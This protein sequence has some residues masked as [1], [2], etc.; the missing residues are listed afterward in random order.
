MGETHITD[1]ILVNPMLRVAEFILNEAPAELHTKYKTTAYRYI[2]YAKKHVIEKWDARETW[3]TD[4]KYAGYFAWDHYL[5]RDKSAWIQADDVRNSA[6]GLPFNKNLDLAITHLRLFRLVGDPAYR[7]RARLICD[8]FKSRLCL[9]KGSYTWNYWEPVY[10]ADIRSIDPPRRGHWVGTHP[11][12][13]YQAGELACVIEAYKNGLTF[14]TEDIDRFVAANLMMWNGSFNEPD[15]VNSDYAVWKSVRKDYQEPEPSPHYGGPAGALWQAM[16]PF[17]ETL[18]RLGNRR[19]DN[20]E[21]LR[22]PGVQMQELEFPFHSSQ[23]FSMVFAIPA[24]VRRGETLIAGCK[25]RDHLDLQV[26]LRTGDGETLIKVIHKGAV[27]WESGGHGGLHFLEWPA[28][29]SPGTYRLRWIAGK[30]YRDFPIE[31][32]K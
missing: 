12:R 13:N 8:S 2:E 24:V 10:P 20:L 11:Y 29:C 6:L 19:A 16:V 5:A 1:A 32:R 28:D 22:L 25:V 31:V 17:S 23:M 15:F 9:F 21:K 27:E 30:D 26:Q 18:A 7:E 3:W 4:G 14:T